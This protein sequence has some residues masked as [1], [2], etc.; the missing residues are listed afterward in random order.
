MTVGSEGA[1]IFHLYDKE[2]SRAVSFP[3]SLLKL[4]EMFQAAFRG[5]VRELAVPFC[6]SVTP[7]TSI[8]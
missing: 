2:D 4:Q 3:G 6:S 5:S 1:D 8:K 7:F